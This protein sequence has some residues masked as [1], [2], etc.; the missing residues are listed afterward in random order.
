MIVRTDRGPD[1]YLAGYIVPVNPAQPPD[2]GDLRGFLDERLP[3]PA[4]PTAW[5]ALPAIPFTVNGKLDVKVLPAPEVSRSGS[6]RVRPRT[7]TES[8][9]LELWRDV[10]QVHELGVTDDF[11][12][13]GGH[14]WPPCD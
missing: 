2:A 8:R 5:V 1:P 14:S 13:L 9:M 6:S 7:E 12:A 11:F 10:L 4:V 3:A